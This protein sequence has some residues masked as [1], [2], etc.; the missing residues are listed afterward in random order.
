VEDF[1]SALDDINADSTMN[2]FPNAIG[3]GGAS[4]TK[5]AVE[6]TKKRVGELGEMLVK[7]GV[8]KEDLEAMSGSGDKAEAAR[9]KVQ[10]VLSANGISDIKSDMNIIESISSTKVGGKQGKDVLLDKKTREAANKAKDSEEGYANVTK[11]ANKKDSVMYEVLKTIGDLA[12]KL[13]PL[14]SDPKNAVRDL[15]AIRVLVTNDKLNV[16]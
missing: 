8:K 10:G 2:R 3:V 13:G 7:G 6:S 4:F 16:S 11:E 5:E 14:L 9:K 1:V 12:T 15:P